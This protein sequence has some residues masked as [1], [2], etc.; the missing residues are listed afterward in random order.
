MTHHANLAALRAVDVT[1]VVGL[2][3]CGAV[4]AGLPL[5]SVVVFDDLYFPSNRLPDGS[6]CTWYL[7]PGEAGRGHWIF[8]QPSANRCAKR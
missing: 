5:G 4:T 3:V 7:E 2:T 1:C 6:R 8:D